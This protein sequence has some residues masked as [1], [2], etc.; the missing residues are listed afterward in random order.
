[1]TYT[2]LLP[3]LNSRWILW[4]K[5]SQSEFG[6]FISPAP[7]FHQYHQ[8][9][10]IIK[11][12]EKGD[13]SFAGYGLYTAMAIIKHLNPIV[14]KFIFNEEH[15][16]S[17]CY[18]SEHFLYSGIFLFSV[19]S[20]F[21][22]FYFQ[23]S[24]CKLTPKYCALL[25]ST[26]N[27]EWGVTKLQTVCTEVCSTISDS[28]ETL[29]E[30]QPLCRFPNMQE[31]TPGLLTVLISLFLVPLSSLEGERSVEAAFLTPSPSQWLWG[32]VYSPEEEFSISSSCANLS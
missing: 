17:K 4:C 10:H 12:P 32:I 6:S 28:R 13:E 30:W 22:I 14:L 1:M 27:T 31:I 19:T 23:R 16:N 3:L 11:P 18:T 24:R 15:T 20:G 26:V 5:W 21:C 7:G 9:C 8:R 2:K 25:W 29:P